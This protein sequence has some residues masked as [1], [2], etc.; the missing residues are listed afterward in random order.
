MEAQTE[1]AHAQ[2]ADAMRGYQVEPHL[3]VVLGGTGDLTRRKLL[4]ALRRLAKLDLL[5]EPRG[6]LAVARDTDLDDES[7]RKWGQSA[8]EDAGF[9]RD[10]VAGV[11]DARL[12]YQPLP[13]GSAADYEALARRVHEVEERCGIPGNRVFYLALPPRV[14][15]EA[16]EGLAAAGLNRGPGWIRLVVE[17]PFGRDLAS[18]RELNAVIH[19]H[20]DE[21]E[22]YRIDHYLGKETVQNLLVFRFANAIF[23]SLW[24]RDRVDNIQITVAEEIGI[25]SRAGYYDRAG[26]L[27]DMVQNHVAQLLALVG[28]EVPATFAADAVR[29]EKV[30]LL[31]SISPLGPE[32]VVFGQYARGSVEGEACPGYLEEEEVD[33]ESDTETFVAL[34]L[35]LDTWRWQGVPFYIRTGKR[36]PRRLTQIAVT[37]QAPPVFLFESLGA[38]G[39]HANVLYL[40]LQPDE[41]FALC[42]DVKVPGEPFE[43]RTLPLDFFYREAFGPIPDAYQTLLLDALTGDQT[44]FVHAEEAEAS[45]ELFDPLTSGER[46]VHLY[47]AGTW[48]PDAADELLA[49]DGRKWLEP[50]AHPGGAESAQEPE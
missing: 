12:Y 5:G 24:S 47:R 11:Y 3:F 8:L 49:R 43:L 41:G 1:P 48:G 7:F 23:E 39:T 22:V 30:K 6:I 42:V 34:K 45:W 29:Y 15:P 37:F 46:R 2:S 32:D 27:R 17:K 19:R 13:D 10:D 40:S 20:F 26:A 44:L 38:R 28:M 14:F 9:A 21:R 33:P 4:P 36:L 50:V 25:G 16:I 35:A 18:A 31:R